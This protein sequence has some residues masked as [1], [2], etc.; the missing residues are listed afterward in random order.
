MLT[1]G[2][3]LSQTRLVTSVHPLTNCAIVRS[4]IRKREPVNLLN[5]IAFCPLLKMLA[6]RHYFIRIEDFSFI[7]LKQSNQP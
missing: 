6:Y 4:R 7:F 2:F 1:Q 3:K 5:E